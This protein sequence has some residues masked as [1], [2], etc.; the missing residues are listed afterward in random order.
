[1]KNYLYSLVYVDI[2][3]LITVLVKIPSCGMI[4]SQLF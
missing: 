1:M 3:I 2:L 4:S